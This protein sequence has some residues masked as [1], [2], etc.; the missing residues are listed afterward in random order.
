[1]LFPVTVAELKEDVATYHDSG[2]DY[3][4]TLDDLEIALASEPV[5]LTPDG[6]PIHEMFEPSSPW[7]KKAVYMRYRKHKE[8]D[9]NTIPA[10]AELVAEYTAFAGS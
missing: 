10:F 8:V 3:T 7:F 6:R 1:M 9:F 2:D 4:V 5:N